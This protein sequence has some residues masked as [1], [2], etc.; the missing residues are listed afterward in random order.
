MRI[1]PRKLRSHDQNHIPAKPRIF[2]AVQ[3]QLARK[4]KLPFTSHLYISPHFYS[5]NDT[6]IPQAPEQNKRGR[7]LFEH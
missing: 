4:Q 6:T 7:G 2:A 1:P 3:A 5:P